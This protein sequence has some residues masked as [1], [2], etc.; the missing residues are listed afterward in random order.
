MPVSR[1]VSSLFPITLSLHLPPFFSIFPSGGFTTAGKPVKVLL[2]E[3]ETPVRRFIRSMLTA[4]EYAVLE[5]ENGR[6]GIS[7][8][9]SHKP[10]VV[11]LDLGLHDMDGMSVFREV[12]EWSQAP[13]I[14][15]SARG[16]EKDKVSALDAGA[17]DYLTKPFGVEE[18]RARIRL[19]LHHTNRVESDDREGETVLELEDLKIDLVRYRVERAGVTIHLTNLEFKLLELLA[20]NFG[21]VLT[22]SF[23]IKEVWGKYLIEEKHPIRVDM[24]ALR[25]KIELG[26]SRPRYILTEQG[27]GYWL[28][29]R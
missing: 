7:M 10:D 25:R 21:R 11:L 17:D 8:I 14:V 16:Q 15:I 26:P 24:A 3:D 19:A 18:L 20:K 12:R 28:V 6:T 22:H 5:A 23:I 9:G 29:E 1:A 2:I 4:S 27:V 13:I